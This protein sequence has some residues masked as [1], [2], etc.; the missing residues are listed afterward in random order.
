MNEQNPPSWVKSYVDAC[1]RHDSQAVVDMMSENI[2][3]V[4]TAFG[5]TFKGKQAAKALIDRMDASFSSD[6]FFTLGKVVES[7]DS[8]SF[9]WVLSGTH[10]R[11]DFELGIPATGKRFECPGVTIGVRANELITENRDY[12]NFA[13]FLMQT[14]LMPSLG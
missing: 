3:V 6:Y 4:D 8:Y 14:G 12:W 5:G 9:E 10:D 13:G 1:N 2:Q 7:G 11:S